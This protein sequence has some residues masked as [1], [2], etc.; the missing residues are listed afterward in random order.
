MI[1]PKKFEP[2]IPN[3]LDHPGFSIS[4]GGGIT[5]QNQTNFDRQN[6]DIRLIKRMINTIIKFSKN[7]KIFHYYLI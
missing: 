3:S 4:T 7:V 2:G 6:C 1:H 5:S